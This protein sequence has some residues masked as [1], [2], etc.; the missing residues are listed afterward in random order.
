MADL[1]AG[2]YGFQH[3]KTHFPLSL[4]LLIMSNS[5]A[6]WVPS[7]LPHIKAAIGILEITEVYLTFLFS[8]MERTISYIAHYFWGEVWW[9][10]TPSNRSAERP[11]SRITI[12]PSNDYLAALWCDTVGWR[13]SLANIP[14]L[15]LCISSQLCIMAGMWSG[16]IHKDVHLLCPF[17]N[18]K[19]GSNGFLVYNKKAEHSNAFSS[20]NEIG[21]RSCPIV[22]PPSDDDFCRHRLWSALGFL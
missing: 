6:H 10:K 11:I 22:S 5:Q 17:I 4:W 15:G 8:Y 7:S 13:G 18:Q 1:I 14:S 3:K 19:E 9:G 2:F 20:F 16:P 12:C 21:I